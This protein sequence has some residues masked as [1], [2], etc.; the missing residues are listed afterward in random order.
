M[1]KFIL[2]KIVQL[3]VADV[4]AKLTPPP[5]STPSTTPPIRL[6]RRTLAQ[7]L[8]DEEQK[9]EAL[10]ATNSA[11]LS[12][13]QAVRIAAQIIASQKTIIGLKARL[14]SLIHP[15]PPVQPS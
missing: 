7:I 13:V 8:L 15:A 2:S 1:W 14:A 9:L 12:A 6:P 3:A 11:A 10:L 5:P 4:M